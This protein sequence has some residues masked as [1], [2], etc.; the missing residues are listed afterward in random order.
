MPKPRTESGPASYVI[1]V[2]PSG[3]ID[4]TNASESLLFVSD[5]SPLMSDLCPAPIMRRMSANSKRMS[6]GLTQ[7]PADIL[8][9]F[10]ARDSFVSDKALTGHFRTRLRI[11][12]LGVRLFSG[13]P[14]SLEQPA[15]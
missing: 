12:R 8:T 2:L 13:V 9:Y 10:R 1:L 4:R 5:I 3:A 7:Y 6:V 11:K 15:C 14:I